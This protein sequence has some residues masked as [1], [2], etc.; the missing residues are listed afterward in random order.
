MEARFGQQ[1]PGV[2]HRGLCED[3]R[4][5]AGRERRFERCH[6]VERHHARLAGDPARQP[7]HLRHDLAVLQ[8][9]QGG[10]SL[11]VVLPVEQQDRPAAGQ[12]A[13]DPD[14]LGVRLRR[15]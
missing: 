3:E 5:V 10:V 9:D 13:G 12:L 6:V 8:D 4:D 11:A 7:A 1:E 2:G 14:H 15:G